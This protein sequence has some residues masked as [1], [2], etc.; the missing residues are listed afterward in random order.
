ML[1]I[2]GSW[3]LGNYVIAFVGVTVLMFG[4]P[5]VL[6]AIESRKAR[7]SKAPASGPGLLMR[8]AEAGRYFGQ[9]RRDGQGR[10]V[11]NYNWRYIDG[12]GHD[13]TDQVHHAGAVAQ[14]AEAVR[15][16]GGRV[17]VRCHRV[18]VAGWRLAVDGGD[19]GS[20]ADATQLT[21]LHDSPYDVIAAVSR[22]AG[23]TSM[24]HA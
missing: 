1:Y 5:F 9:Q 11:I 3:I 24:E 14:I 8:I 6:A 15:V 19:L 10:P 22:A 4:P 21:A 2:H 12:A 7:P 18:G 20:Q 16:D 13:I 17:L 23:L